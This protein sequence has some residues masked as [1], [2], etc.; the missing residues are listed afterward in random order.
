MGLLNWN[1]SQ[2]YE[3]DAKPCTQCDTTTPLRSHAGEPVHKVCAEDW[4]DRNPNAARVIHDDGQ[5]LG[6]TRYHSDRPR[7]SRKE[8][9]R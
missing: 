6:T 3:S 2:H 4:N 1:S 7:K 5:D 8:G 9:A